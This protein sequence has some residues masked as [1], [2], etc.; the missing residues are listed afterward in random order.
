MIVCYLAVD[1]VVSS[2]Q[3]HM[4]S[5]YAVGINLLYNELDCYSLNVLCEIL[6]L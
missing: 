3:Q 2:P 6:I 4:P 1:Y 5:G